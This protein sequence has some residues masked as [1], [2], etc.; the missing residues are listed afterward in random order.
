MK[1]QRMIALLQVLLLVPAVV[2]QEAVTQ[3]A[4]DLSDLAVAFRDKNK[5]PAVSVAIGD[6]DSLVYVK[7]FGLADLEN[8][9]QATAET[10]FRTAS[11]AKPITAMAVLQLVDKGKIS[12]DDPIRKH[13]PGVPEKEYELTVRQLLCHQA[14]IRHYNAPGEAQ[15]GQGLSGSISKIVSTSSRSPAPGEAL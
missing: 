3:P 10:V 12:L 11:I 7:A 4:T 13:C 5:V 9:V 15:N 1:S 2:A 6:R 8:S 14:G